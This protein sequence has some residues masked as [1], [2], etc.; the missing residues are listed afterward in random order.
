MA[1]LLVKKNADII[2]HQYF[3]DCP[4]FI[5]MERHSVI[6]VIGHRPPSVFISPPRFVF[7]P[8]GHVI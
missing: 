4:L 2:L 5:W 8:R 1:S 6:I 7:G 3:K